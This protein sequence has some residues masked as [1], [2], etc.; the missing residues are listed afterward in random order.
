[1]RQLLYPALFAAASLA[2]LNVSFTNCLDRSIDSPRFIP[3][4]VSADLN[5]TS[6][7]ISYEIYGNMSGQIN[8]TN[9]DN[10]LASALTDTITFAGYTESKIDMRLCQLSRNPVLPAE[11]GYCPFGPGPVLLEF[12]TTLNSSFVFASVTSQIR[13]N[14]PTATDYSVGCVQVTITPPFS[15]KIDSILTYVPLAI[16]LL[17]GLKVI[18]LALANP[19]S[20]TADPYRAFSYFGSDSNAVRMATPG[21]ADCLMY[22]QFV[23]YSSMLRLNYPGFFQPATS[24]A[25][26]ALLLFDSSPISKALNYSPQ[27]SASMTTF[28]NFVG[29]SRQDAWKSF[30]VWWLIAL[31]CTIALAVVIISLWWV[32]TPSSTDLTQKNVPFIGGC[33]LRIYYWFLIPMSIFTSYQLVTAQ[34]SAASL[35]AL[36]ALVLM[37][38]IAVFPAALTYY[39]TCYRPR[40]DLYDDLSLLNLFGPLYNT[41]SAHA[42]LVLIPNILLSIVRGFVVGFL[43]EYGTAQIVLLALFELINLTLFMFMRPWPQNTNTTLFSVILHA[44]RFVTI[45]LLIPFLASLDIA[46]GSRERVG[47]AILVIHAFVL[48]F[49]FLGN[50]LLTLLELLIRLLVIV[51]QDEG[52]RA[53]FGARQLKSRKRRKDIADSHDPRAPDTTASANSLTA[54]ID[55][56][57]QSPFFR[58]PR[59]GSRM[60]SRM[61][62]ESSIGD[63]GS[64]TRSG[65]VISPY[66]DTFY[67]PGYNKVN[68]APLVSS[69]S[70]GSEDLLETISRAETTTTSRLDF[71]HDMSDLALAPTEDAARRGVD[72]AVREA[73]VYHPQSSGELLGP[74]KKLGT[75]PADP[76]GIKFR[77]FSW[78]PWRKPVNEEKGKFVVVR[79]APAPQ[80]SSSIPT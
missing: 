58:T 54:L 24:R 32:L 33:I 53:I 1:M 25:A 56:K 49:G 11:T 52:A 23:A 34:Q 31:A 4:Y 59:A 9:E 3:L 27:V 6:G 79:S 13:I 60:S 16:L 71:P 80:H 38:L 15:E 63:F 57:E 46:S 40:Q 77:K 30:M 78:T 76:N 42:L 43:Q 73:D 14:G 44:V 8:D 2:A 68:K 5:A 18:V 69:Y 55:N 26:W 66:Q 65:N 10:T 22:I 47:Y 64:I 37:V 45:I 70:Y 20:G 17:V 61:G 74:S 51:P 36:S 75:G 72:Y 29:A 48:V 67:N 19:W 28:I 21:F 12:N 41:Y 39:L 50:V 35:T 62:A 7:V